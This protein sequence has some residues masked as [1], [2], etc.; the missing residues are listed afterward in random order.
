MLH[1]IRIVLVNTS[2]PGNIG[3]AARAMKTMGLSQLYLVG[4]KHFPS[5]EASSRASGADDV[6][7]NAVLC[8]SLPSALNGCSLVVGT[9]ARARSLSALVYDPRQCSKQLIARSG[10]GEAVAV[11]FGCEQS[12]LTNEELDYCQAYV[13]IPASQ[14]Y[15]SLNLAAAV[16]VLSYE[17]RMQ[18]L[19]CQ[20]MCPG[21]D[22]VDKTQHPLERTATFE[23]LDGLHRHL[24][25]VLHE[26]EFLR[27]RDGTIV[28]RR[29]KLMCDRA[30]P[31]LREVYIL[32]GILSAVQNIAG[33]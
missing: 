20:S 22:D 9:T 28:M 10:A 1:S 21:S 17:I 19:A 25:T 26:I 23:A 16:Q 27:G 2:H 6:L 24:E 29:L 7:N 3:A 32:R 12:G 15:G 5:Q 18:M 13:H 33:K 31:S 8:E 14:E 30:S 11:V 4:P